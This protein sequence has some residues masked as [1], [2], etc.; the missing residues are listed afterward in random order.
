[1]NELELQH[2][3]REKWRL[4]GEPLRT[5][6]EAREF[7][8]SVGLC[9]MYPVLP[10]PLLPTFIAASIGSDQQLPSS[11]IKALDSRAENAEALAHRLM[12]EKFVFMSPVYGGLLISQPVFPYFYALNSDRKPKQP[13]RSRQRGKASPLAEHTFLKLE[14]HGPLNAAQL[15]ERL[16]GELSP[17]A[18]GRVLHELWEAL[19]IVPIDYSSDSG[20]TWDVLYR[21]APEPV[22]EGVRLSDA[23]ALSA[24]ISKY[25]D[26]VVA[27][28]Q[29]DVEDFFSAF[30]SRS[31]VRQVMNA[32][33]AAR[34]FS[35]LPGEGKTL[36]TVTHREAAAE[37]RPQRER[38]VHA[39]RRRNA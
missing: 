37:L 30:A 8:D 14:A 24:L 39:R 33:L 17:S 2:L 16:G 3:R 27:A 26:S 23:E 12:H 31:R 9:L 18:I 29:E 11:K 20:N 10:M 25:L 13:L 7:V 6:E 21:W 34:E 15:Q 28:T 32:L 4:E 5:L 36:I 19:K 1:M 22:S 38:L 35:Y